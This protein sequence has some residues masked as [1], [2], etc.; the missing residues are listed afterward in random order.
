[1]PEIMIRCPDTGDAI[2]TDLYTETVILETMPPKIALPI[3]CPA[4]GRTHFWK[5]SDAWAKG[6]KSSS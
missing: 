2:S 4:C 6:E 1:M 3:Q 5:R